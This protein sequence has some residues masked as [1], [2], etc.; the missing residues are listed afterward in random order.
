[1]LDVDLGVDVGDTAGLPIAEMI[2]RRRL[3]PTVFQTNVRCE[4]ADGLVPSVP[5]CD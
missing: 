5:L 1:M 2:W 4:T 3:V